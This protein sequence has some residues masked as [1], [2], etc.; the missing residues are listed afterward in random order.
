VRRIGFDGRNIDVQELLIRKS[1]DPS[2]VI[3]L[4]R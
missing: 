4:R 1:V 3:H 2:V